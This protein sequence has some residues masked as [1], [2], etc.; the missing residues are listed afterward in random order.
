MPF[1]EVTFHGRWL[2]EPS[3]ARASA[4]ATSFSF[5]FEGRSLAVELEGEAQFRIEIDGVETGELR[6]RERNLYVVAQNLEA[7]LHQASIVKKTETELGCIS[8][9]RIQPEPVPRSPS[10]PNSRSRLEFIG[11]SYT[12]GFGN[13][14]RD[15]IT[16]TAFTTTD[17]TRSYGA[18]TAQ[19]LGADFQINAYS[20]RGLVQ[21]Y[22]GIAPRWNTPRL[23]EY[24]LGGE[25]MLGNSPPWDFSR[26]S[27]DVV[28][29]FI[30]IN[31]WQGECCH[32]NPQLFDTAYADFLNILRTHYESPQFVLLSTDIY[33]QNCLSER[34]ESVCAREIS[35]GNRDVRHL[36]LETPRNAGLDF[37]PHF[38]RHEQMAKALFQEIQ[39]FSRKKIVL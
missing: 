10:E 16:G 11:D 6:T 33:P 12:V 18:L 23:Y 2:L 22:M 38:A 27:P 39:S 1:S 34:V 36:Y 28:C 29:L 8:L 31:D 35:K 7:G 30:G 26:F 24:A 37:H 3:A 14:A 15:P 20:G 13:M 17:A 25:A 5:A 21:N 32:P 9:F 19:K 4:P